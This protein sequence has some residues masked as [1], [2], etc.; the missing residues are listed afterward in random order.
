MS[1]AR[2]SRDTRPLLED[3]RTRVFRLDAEPEPDRVGLEAEFLLR[4]EGGRTPVSLEGPGR[5]LA[6]TAELADR[7]GWTRGD[8]GSVAPR[9][10]AA[11][12]CAVSFEPGGQLEVASPPASSPGAALECMDEVLVPL[13]RAYSAEG[14][15]LLDAGIDPCAPS[16]AV[17]LQLTTPRYRRMAAYFARRGPAGRRMMRQTASIHIN[18]DLGPDPL[19]RWRVANALA[20]ALTAV[21][22]NSSVYAGALSGDRN[23]RAEQWRRLDPLRTGTPVSSADPIETYL[24][25][26]LAA[27]AIL[28][29]PAEAEARPFAHWWNEGA[30]SSDWRAHLTTLFPEVRPRGYLEIRSVDQ[31]PAAWRP[32]PVSFVTGVLYSPAALAEADVSLPLPGPE[33]LERAGAHGLEDPDISARARTAWRIAL[34]GMEERQDLITSEHRARA[35][36]F[37]ERFTARGRDPGQEAEEGRG[38]ATAERD[39]VTSEIQ[40]QDVSAS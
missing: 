9:W 12:G 24:R 19:L 7:L 37:Y 14:W 15:T 8:Q 4:A 26:A 27:P 11:C 39:A 17:E 5:A 3:L 32:V 6:V 40:G 28:M 10:W 23:H 29:G 38:T 31:L 35:R 20:P 36:A 2:P 22:A 13:D 33:D 1:P 25:F 30:E 21:F 16:Q 34:A 18:V